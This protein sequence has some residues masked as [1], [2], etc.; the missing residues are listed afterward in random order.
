MLI[1]VKLKKLRTQER[2]LECCQ[3]I[4]QCQKAVDAASQD[5][6]PAHK[7]DHVCETTFHL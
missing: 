3:H 5:V 1:V 7:I 2:R 6:P 4:C